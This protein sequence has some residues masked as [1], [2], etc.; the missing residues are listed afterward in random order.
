MALPFILAQLVRIGPGLYGRQV[1][2]FLAV[3]AIFVLNE[4]MARAYP[5]YK[6]K[7][8]GFSFL[9]LGASGLMGLLGVFPAILYLPSLLK[10]L[11]G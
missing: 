5:E 9:N 4:S 2:F 7:I 6:W 10:F 3:T 1:L 8:R 11:L